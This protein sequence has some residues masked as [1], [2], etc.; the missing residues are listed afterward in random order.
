MSSTFQAVLKAAV[1]AR[2]WTQSEAAAALGIS[3]SQLSFYQTGQR[4]PALQTLLQIAERL[5][6]SLDELSGQAG[7]N[8]IIM[9]ETP[10]GSGAHLEAGFMADLRREWHRHPARRPGIELAVRSLWPA[11]RAEEVLTWLN[12]KP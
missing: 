4:E 3:Q 5:N 10:A 7:V 9:R 12:L 1:K 6:I 8:Q 2:G 11:A